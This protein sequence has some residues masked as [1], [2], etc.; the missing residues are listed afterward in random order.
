MHHRMIKKKQNQFEE[1]TK[2]KVYEKILETF[3]DA[4]LISIEKNENKND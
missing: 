3:P 1:A 4:K 2:T